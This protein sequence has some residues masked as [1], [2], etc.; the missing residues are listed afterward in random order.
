MWHSGG[1]LTADTL[2]ETMWVEWRVVAP[3]K[4]RK[5]QTMRCLPTVP[6]ATSGKIDERTW[7][8]RSPVYCNLTKLPAKNYIR[9]TLHASV[10]PFIKYDETEFLVRTHM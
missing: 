8:W 10:Q 5:C 7:W 9:V 3:A 1:P 2:I 4:R 6:A